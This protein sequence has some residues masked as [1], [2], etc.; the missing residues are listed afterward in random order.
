MNV[1]GMFGNHPRHKFIA[2][3]LEKEGKLRGIVIEEREEHVPDAPE[4]LSDHLAQLYEHHFDLRAKAE[5]QFFGMGQFPEVPQLRVSHDELNSE[6]VHRF[7]REKSPEVTVTYGVHILTNKTLN[8]IPGDVW[9]VH[10]GLSPEY[11]GVITHFWPS[12]LLK[13]QMTGV[14]LHEITSKIDGGSIVH[15]T[16]AP[17]VSGDGIHQLA[18][19]TVR[20]F[21]KELP[22]VINIAANGELSELVEQEH[23]GK[24]WTSNDWEPEHLLVIYEAFD[25]DI[26]D[27][28]LNGEFTH[29]DPELIR[30]F[31]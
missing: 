18:C 31:E 3:Q 24:L 23:S 25:N 5:K 13:P 2:R 27:R 9:N 19:R 29:R 20:E 30:Q 21:G 6:K 1:V 10:G 26:V 8:E 15:Q 11:R 12:Y 22:Q 17:L 16:G 7:I 4:R 14:T 28:Y